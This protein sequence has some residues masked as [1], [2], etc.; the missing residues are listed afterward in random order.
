MHAVHVS[1]LISCVLT[2]CVTIP[3]LANSVGLSFSI[4][5]GNSETMP[6]N[7]QRKVWRYPHANFDHA[8]ELLDSTDWDS[9]FDTDN[10]NTCWANWHSKF[11][12]IMDK[13]IPQ[14]LRWYYALTETCHG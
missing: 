11:M 10:M 14:D 2:G 8:C 1:L 3:A 7:K 6:K 5:A 12:E 9:V 4:S 13:C